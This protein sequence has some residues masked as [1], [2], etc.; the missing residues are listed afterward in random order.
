MSKEVLGLFIIGVVC[1]IIS[2]FFNWTSALESPIALNGELQQTIRRTDTIKTDYPKTIVF[3]SD[4]FLPKTVAGSEVS[5]YETIKYLR[6]RGHTITLFLKEYTVNTYGGFEIFKY[7]PEDA[8]CVNAILDADVVLFQMGD[9]YTNFEIIQSR[10]KPVYVF[11]HLV[12]R[13]DWILQQKVKFPMTVVYNSNMTRTI[14]PT[15]HDNMLMIPYV[16]IDRFKYLRKFTSNNKIVCLINYNHNKGGALLQELAHKMPSVQFLG[17]KGS[18]S[19]QV[20]DTSPPENLTYIENQPD[21][22]VV[23]KKIGILIMP[24]KNETW[25]RTAVEA[26]ASGVPVIHSEAAGLVECVGGA[27]VM[28]TRDDPDAWA[29]SIRK[30]L[31]DSTYR[32]TLRQYG[33]NRVKEIDYQQTYG[34]QE[35]AMRIERG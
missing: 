24:S 14:L 29:E 34:R 30:I 33:F 12:D 8:K 9:E 26:M 28:C 15:L 31:K 3:L 25:G 11:I 32:E 18:Y 5:G 22:L 17:V 6:N 27:G 10:T 19:N 1:I 21:I 4:S 20:M 23:F 2:P 7:S 16:D 35:L 13:Y